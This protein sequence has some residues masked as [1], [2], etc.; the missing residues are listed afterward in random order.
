MMSKLKL[1]FD[2]LRDK[3][4]FLHSVKKYFQVCVNALF[5]LSK[6]M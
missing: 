2:E 3:V 1:Q 6:H 4:Q 5:H